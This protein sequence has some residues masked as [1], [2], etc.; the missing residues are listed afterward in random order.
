MVTT[1][2]GIGPRDSHEDPLNLH[3]TNPP[4][5][6]ADSVS[7]DRPAFP[8]PSSR[9]SRDESRDPYHLGHGDH[10]SAN[11]VPKILTG[12]ENYTSWRRSMMVALLARNKVHFITGKLPQP[13]PTHED[14]DSWCRCN[15]T[16][17]SWILHAVSSEIADSVMYLDDASLIWSDLY[18][19]FHQNNGPRV[20]EVK[21][22]L[23]VLHQGSHS[24]QTY[25]TRLKALWDLVNEYRPQPLCTC[26]AMKT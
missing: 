7:M 22:S 24:I 1:R 18:E 11:L 10:P 17:I 19:R 14:Y 9:S 4:V 20:F 8:N 3:D 21:R 5:I 12:G 2:S 15:S 23:Q 6:P 26:G 13:A 25:F 16:V